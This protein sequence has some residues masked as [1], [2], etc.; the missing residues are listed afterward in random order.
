MTNIMASHQKMALSETKMIWRM[1]TMAKKKQSRDSGY[2]STSTTWFIHS[3]IHSLIG[4]WNLLS[5][6]A[7]THDSGKEC[8]V[9]GRRQNVEYIGTDDRA[10]TDVAFSHESTEDVEE[11]FRDGRPH[12]H[13]GS[14]GYV[15]W[16]V[17]RCKMARFRI[18]LLFV[19]NMHIHKYLSAMRRV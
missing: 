8:A 1:T 3:F 5:S 18:R 14:S 11:Q 17:Q 19:W 10:D 7:V 12:G 16:Q 4:W 9:S 15:R 6:L 2:Q 13:D